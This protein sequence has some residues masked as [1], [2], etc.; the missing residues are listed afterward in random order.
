MAVLLCPPV[1][2]GLFRRT[3]S[4]A[5][6][7]WGWCIGLTRSGHTIWWSSID[8]RMFILP[9]THGGSRR[10]AWSYLCIR[11][12]QLVVV[13]NVARIGGWLRLI[14]WMW[15]AIWMTWRIRSLHRQTYRLGRSKLRIMSL[16]PMWNMRAHAHLTRTIV[17][18]ANTYREL[19]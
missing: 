11:R 16:H 14:C 9:R 4:G 15:M 5:C 7:H 18:G 10:C 19:L 12:C 13:V 3:S 8:Q 6:W 1:H 17:V 2:D